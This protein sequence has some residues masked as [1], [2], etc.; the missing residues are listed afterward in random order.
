MN[1]E[2]EDDDLVRFEAHGADPRQRTSKAGW[3]MTA[4]PV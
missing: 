2:T 3:T 1:A 4:P